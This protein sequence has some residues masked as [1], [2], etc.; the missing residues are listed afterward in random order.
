MPT[1]TVSSSSPPS[2]PLPWAGSALPPTLPTPRSSATAAAATPH[3]KDQRLRRLPFPR[4]L[5]PHSHHRIFAVRTPPPPTLCLEH[6]PSNWP[7]RRH[8][9]TS[10]ALMV[11]NYLASM[12]SCRPHW[13]DSS[14]SC[15]PCRPH[16]ILWCMV[17]TPYYRLTAKTG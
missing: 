1:M 4:P 7:P 16:C 9:W 12:A 11:K 15:W 14:A 5:P 3:R 6:W 10:L 8:L 13:M 17:S 2:S